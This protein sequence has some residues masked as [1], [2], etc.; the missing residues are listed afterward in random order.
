MKF[1]GGG[2]GNEICVSNGICL[3]NEI[4]LGNEISYNISCLMPLVEF[5]SGTNLLHSPSL[6][7]SINLILYPDIPQRYQKEC[8]MSLDFNFSHQVEAIFRFVSGRMYFL[9]WINAGS[10]HK[11]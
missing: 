11:K 10:P 2:G 1:A 5:V 7:I 3:G 9:K 8:G 6:Y 4:Y